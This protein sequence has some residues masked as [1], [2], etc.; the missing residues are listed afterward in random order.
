MS[1]QYFVQAKPICTANASGINATP[2]APQVQ[3]HAMA[4]DG[5]TFLMRCKPDEQSGGVGP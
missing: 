5:L 4:R 3:R 2:K 1:K